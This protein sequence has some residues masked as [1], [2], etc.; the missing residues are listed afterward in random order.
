MCRGCSTPLR[1]FELNFVAFPRAKRMGAVS[2]VSF[3]A[4]GQ[5]E[6]RRMI[7]LDRRAISR[8]NRMSL[9]P[10]L[11]YLYM[12]GHKKKKYFFMACGMIAPSSHISAALNMRDFRWI[13]SFAL[14][15]LD[16]AKRT[17]SLRANKQSRSK[18]RKRSCRRSSSFPRQYTIQQ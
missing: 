12:T 3:G 15:N 13:R 9:Y 8:I 16:L 17:L 5:R 6:T 11:F 2:W 18:T 4:G 10:Y 7:H 14:T 1:S